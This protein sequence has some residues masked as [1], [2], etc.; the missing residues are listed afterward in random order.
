MLNTG[1]ISPSMTGSNVKTS[2]MY[3]PASV[4]RIFAA[5]VNSLRNEL[6]PIGD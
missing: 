2:V 5:F 6:Y 3:H 4:K 1:T